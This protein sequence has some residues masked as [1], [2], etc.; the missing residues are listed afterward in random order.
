LG[1][2][3]GYFKYQ[4]TKEADVPVKLWQRNYYEHIIRDEQGY[5]NIARYIAENPFYWAMDNYY[6]D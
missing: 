4:T 3:I 1:N 2:I 5:S 6:V